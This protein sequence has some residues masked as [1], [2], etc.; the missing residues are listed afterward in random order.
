MATQYAIIYTFLP[1]RIKELYMV[2][3][4][5]TRMSSRGQVVIPEAIRIRC[6]FG[7]GTTFT[8]TVTLSNSE[9]A[10]LKT[11]DFNLNPK[12]L[13]VLVIDDDAVACKH[14]HIVLEEIGIAS[15]TCMSG[16]EAIELIQTRHARHD[17]YNLIL[18]DWKMP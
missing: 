15:D 6:G 11:E 18:V 17:P 10:N 12:E 7:E 1:I 14:A 3:V 4:P 13:K 5:T 8:V 2:A 16:T 9:N